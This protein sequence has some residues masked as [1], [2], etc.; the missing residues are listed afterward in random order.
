M[1]TSGE[2]PPELVARFGELAAL[3]PGADV[4]EVFGHPSCVLRGNMFMGLYEGS[5]LLRLAEPDRTEFLRRYG[6]VLF[7]PL[8]GRSMKEFVV[9][10]STL[11]GTGEIE[12]WVRRSFAYAEQ[13][14]PR[15]DGKT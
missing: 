9:V 11:A 1:P 15:D 3:A 14:P 6:G 8:P 12:D 2:S 10:P 5:L 13:L 7:E 4:R